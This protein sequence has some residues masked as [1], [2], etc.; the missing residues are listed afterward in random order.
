MTL[1][2]LLFPLSEHAMPDWIRNRALA[3]ILGTDFAGLNDDVR[4]R[5][6]DRL[7]PHRDPIEF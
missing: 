1:N 4:Y 2:R 6:L 5:N 3:D 7:H